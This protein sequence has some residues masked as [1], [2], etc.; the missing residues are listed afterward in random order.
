VIGRST[1]SHCNALTRK[2]VS[3]LIPSFG[4]V[5]SLPGRGGEFVSM[6]MEELATNPELV[7]HR[8]EKV[9]TDCCGKENGER[10]RLMLVVVVSGSNTTRFSGESEIDEREMVESLTDHEATHGELEMEPMSLS[11]ACGLIFLP[12]KLD[13]KTEGLEGARIVM[14]T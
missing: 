6:S 12:L 1:S 9:N 11:L 10:T 2:R 13:K 4:T 7:L 8:N 14:R 3:K 5:V